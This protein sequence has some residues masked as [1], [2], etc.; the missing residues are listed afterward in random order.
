M[1]GRSWARKAARISAA[2]T[3]RLIAPMMTGL[4]SRKGLLTRFSPGS[5]RKRWLPRAARSPSGFVGWSSQVTPGGAGVVADRDGH[6]WQLD[7]AL[8]LAEVEVEPRAVDRGPADLLQLDGQHL[9]GPV[10]L[11][12]VALDVGGE[13]AQVGDV[14]DQRRADPLDQRRRLHR[15]V[16]D[17]VERAEDRV[18]ILVEVAHELLE[19][20]DQLVELLVAVGDMVEHLAEVV[21]E[22]ADDL[23]AVGQ[24]VGHRGG[25]REEALEGAAL[26]LEDLDDLVGQ[27]VDVGGAERLEQRLEAVEQHRQVERRGGARDRDGGAV[28]QLR[29][30]PDLLA[31]GDVAL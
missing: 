27:L 19:R 8:E 14:V 28:V 1:M 7:L 13:L 12:A 15:E 9:Q 26:A 10:E 16:R 21:D 17:L 24:G 30:R 29:R 6:P 3:A 23:V 25:V 18:A 11:A 5:P 31:Q 22:S 20:R 2:I 4:R